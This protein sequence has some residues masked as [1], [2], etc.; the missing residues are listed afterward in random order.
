ML[1]EPGDLLLGGQVPNVDLFVGPGR[2]QP[3]A[4]RSEEKKLPAN[5]LHRQLAARGFP[6]AQSRPRQV[7]GYRS[8]SSGRSVVL[9]VRREVGEVSIAAGPIV[10]AH[11]ADGEVEGRCRAA[12]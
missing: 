1:A 6:D 10:L 4:V 8:V 7:S 3:L 9:P 5:H 12:A 2:D 11:L